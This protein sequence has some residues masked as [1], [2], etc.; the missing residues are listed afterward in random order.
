[1]LA[2]RYIGI[3]YSYSTYVVYNTS[4]VPM[5]LSFM[6]RGAW[7]RG[8]KYSYTY[9]IGIQTVH[10]GIQLCGLAHRFCTQNN[11]WVCLKQI[12]LKRHSPSKISVTMEIGVALP[13]PSWLLFLLD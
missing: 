1:M 10:I 3:Q 2:Y 12:Q 5:L 8:Y 7:V 6:W 11:G 13:S 4:L 9:I